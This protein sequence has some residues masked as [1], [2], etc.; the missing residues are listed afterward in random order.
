MS[1]YP[2]VYTNAQLWHKEGITCDNVV[3]AV[4]DSGVTT[5][6][7]LNIIQGFSAFEDGS[8]QDDNSHGTHVAGIIGSKKYGVAPGVKILPVKIAN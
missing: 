4:I 1:N 8:T 7:D 3:V 2:K 6:P 5:H